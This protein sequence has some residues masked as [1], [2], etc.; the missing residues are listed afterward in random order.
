MSP[1]GLDCRL[2][3]KQAHI[4]HTSLDAPANRSVTCIECATLLLTM[5]SITLLPV[6]W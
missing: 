5:R 4:K 3:W 1:S 6:S 2:V